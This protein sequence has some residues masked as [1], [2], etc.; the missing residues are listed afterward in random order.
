LEQP[1]GLSQ[2]AA[3]F[4]VVDSTIRDTVVFVTGM[5]TAG[6][7]LVAAGFEFG[8]GRVVVMTAPEA[9]RNDVL[10]LCERKE[11]ILAVR[12]FEWLSDG[13]ERTVVFD[14]YHHGY[15][16]HTTANEVIRGLLISEPVGRA[17]LH[18]SV[19]GLLLLVAAAVRPLAPRQRVRIE[20]RSPLEHVGALSRAYERVSATGRGARLLV[21]GL[22]RRHDTVKGLSGS[23]EEYLRAL[24]T[25]YPRMEAQV[26][27]L[28]SS[29]ERRITPTEFVKV[30]EAI[31]QI[32]RCI[33]REYN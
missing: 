15:G 21:R 18:G 1:V 20:R 4:R 13:R 12:M 14:E 7:R 29:L 6:K 2:I 16:E 17:L 24:L 31:A 27:L 19:A 28:I 30:G 22:R 10:R 3:A 26:E 33:S 11:A 25:R 5:S 9:L 8:S 23:D 32:E